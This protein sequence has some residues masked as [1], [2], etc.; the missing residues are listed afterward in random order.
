MIIID[1]IKVGDKG[2]VR[3]G[4]QTQSIIGYNGI[5]DTGNVGDIGQVTVV[6]LVKR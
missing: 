2:R 4:P 3:V 5:K 1:S 6:T